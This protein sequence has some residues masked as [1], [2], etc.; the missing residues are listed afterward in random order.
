MYQQLLRPTANEATKTAMSAWALEVSKG[1]VDR[2]PKEEYPWTFRSYNNIAHEMIGSWKKVL[3]FVKTNWE[4]EIQDVRITFVFKVEGMFHIH[5]QTKAIVT[6]LP[7]VEEDK[8]LS[9]TSSVVQDAIIETTRAMDKFRT[10]V[11][12]PTPEKLRDELLRVVPSLIEDAMGCSVITAL[13]LPHVLRDL[14]PT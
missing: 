10:E 12:A 1:I 9:K 5:G 2:L 3:F 11:S 4:G 14:P 7:E 13:T 6:A 8:E